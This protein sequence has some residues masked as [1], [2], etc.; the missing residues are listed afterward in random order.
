MHSHEN[1]PYDSHE[2]YEHGDRDRESS[3]RDEIRALRES[4]PPRPES[5]L[6]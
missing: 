2:Q 5:R 4:L 3:K 1:N 6:N